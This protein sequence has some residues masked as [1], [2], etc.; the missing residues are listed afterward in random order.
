MGKKEKNVHKEGL[1][2]WFLATVA[3]PIVLVS[4]GGGGYGGGGG[5]LYDEKFVKGSSIFPDEGPCY[6]RG[7]VKHEEKEKEGETRM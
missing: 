5:L 6:C 3:V 2:S 4:C 7:Q 1:R